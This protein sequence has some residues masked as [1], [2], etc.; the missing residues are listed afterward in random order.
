MCR[1]ISARRRRRRRR[2]LGRRGRTQHHIVHA[3]VR[4]QRRLARIVGAHLH[5]R[6]VLLVGR[7]GWR[8]H[9]LDAGTVG[10]AATVRRRLVADA[11]R[12]IGRVRRRAE[13]E[14]NEAK[15]EEVG[16]PHVGTVVFGMAL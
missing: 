7:A 6:P 12:P 5:S 9:R 14:A 15:Q 2:S 16:A 10:A 11:S 1:V 13:N 3:P 8:T 4:L